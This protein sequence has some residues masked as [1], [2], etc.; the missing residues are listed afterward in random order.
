MN[1]TSG[2]ILSEAKNPR[3]VSSKAALAGFLSVKFRALTLERKRACILPGPTHGDLS[4]RS[5]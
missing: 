4:L 3:K 5:R 1:F 2:V